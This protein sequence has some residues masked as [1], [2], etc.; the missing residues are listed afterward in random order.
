MKAK[1]GPVGLLLG[2]RRSEVRHRFGMIDLVAGREICPETRQPSS[3]C[4]RR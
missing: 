1:P 2:S 3:R 4:W